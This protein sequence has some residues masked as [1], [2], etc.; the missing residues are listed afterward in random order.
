MHSVDRKQYH[1]IRLEPSKQNAKK[2]THIPT[3]ENHNQKVQNYKWPVN[4]GRG[5]V[6]VGWSSHSAVIHRGSVTVFAD[7]GAFW[8]SCIQKRNLHSAVDWHV[9]N[10]QQTRPKKLFPIKKMTNTSSMDTSFIICSK[11]RVSSSCFWVCSAI[12]SANFLGFAILEE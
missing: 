8:S 3:A 12:F 9:N 5:S 1:S 2:C 10:D 11:A 4:Q 7:V 6:R